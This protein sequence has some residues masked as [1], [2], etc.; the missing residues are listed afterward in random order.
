MNVDW[1]YSDATARTDIP[2]EIQFSG[3]DSVDPGSGEVLSSSI[4]S[5]ATA[6]EFRFTDLEDSVTS[7][8]AG[9]SLPIELGKFLVEPGGGYAYTEKGRSYLQ[10]QIGLGTTA[11]AAVP[12]LVGTPGQVF[13]DENI[14]DPSNGFVMSLGGIG[15]ESYLA[16]ETVMR[17]GARSM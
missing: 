14:L 10:T 9:V 11:A 8:G 16:G 17:P 5:S 12:A 7:Y 4:R 1:Y 6:A 2:N 3:I 15:T 13:T